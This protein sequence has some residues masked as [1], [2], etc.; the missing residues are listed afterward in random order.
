LKELVPNDEC[1][2]IEMINHARPNPRKCSGLYCIRGSVV[3]STY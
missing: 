1:T 3:L 2:C